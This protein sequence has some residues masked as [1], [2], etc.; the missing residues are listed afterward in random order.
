MKNFS[1]VRERVWLGFSLGSRRKYEE[2]ERVPATAGEAGRQ[3]VERNR[4]ALDRLYRL[5]HERLDADR[6]GQ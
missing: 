1:G 3:V 5:F 4:G 2:R 6:N